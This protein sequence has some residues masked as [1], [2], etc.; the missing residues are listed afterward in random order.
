MKKSAVVA[1]TIFLIVSGWFLS[2]QISVGNEK[3]T[4]Q[5]YIE[6]TDEDNNIKKNSSLKVESLLFYAET[7]DQ[8]IVLQGQTIHNRTIDV[9][10]QTTGNI[11]KKNFKSIQ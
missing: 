3:T 1:F 4:D 6:N 7:I 9:K 2:G 10:S 8:S 5:S 11:V